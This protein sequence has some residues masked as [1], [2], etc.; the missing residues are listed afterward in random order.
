[1]NVSQNFKFVSCLQIAKSALA[2]VPALPGTFF[3][4]KNRLGYADLYLLIH[5]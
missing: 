5:F 3:P 1:M 4:I 2:E